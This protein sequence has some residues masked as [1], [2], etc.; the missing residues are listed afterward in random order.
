MDT[1]EKFL[2]K[3]QPLNLGV[4]QLKE[5]YETNKDFV[6]MVCDKPDIKYR[7][8]WISNIDWTPIMIIILYA[9]VCLSAI[10]EK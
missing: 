5:I 1:F 8:C 2:E 9:L 10:L 7:H 3:S 4:D 6:Y